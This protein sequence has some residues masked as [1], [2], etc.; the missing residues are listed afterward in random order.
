MHEYIKLKVKPLTSEM[1]AT[2]VFSQTRRHLCIEFAETIAAKTN[3]SLFVPARS[4]ICWHSCSQPSLSDV[5]FDTCSDI[6]CAGTPCVEF[7]KLECTL[8]IA[9]D[10]FV[11][12]L[13]DTQTASKTR[14]LE[15]APEP[16]EEPPQKVDDAAVKNAKRTRRVAKKLLGVTKSVCESMRENPSTALE[17]RRQASLLWAELDDATSGDA[18]YDCVT[19]HATKCDFWFAQGFGIAAEAG[20]KKEHVRRLREHMRSS[21]PERRRKLE[22]G[23]DKACCRVN[24]LTKERACKREYCVKAMKQRAHAR[25]GHVLRRMHE[26]GHVE[27]SVEQ[28]VA[29]DT[30]SPHLH[31]DPR[32]RAMDAHAKRVD[33]S[34][35]DVECLASSMV[36]H[37]ADKHGISTSRVDEELSKYGLSV[38]QLI[39]QPLKTAGTA[40][41]A[42]SSFKSNPAFADIAARVRETQRRSNEAGG[43]RKMSKRPARALHSARLALEALATDAALP[44]KPIKPVRHR[45]GT[46]KHSARA[47]L[48]NASYFVA[49]V[50]DAMKR[51][52]ANSEAPRA[53]SANPALLQ[54][55]LDVITAVVESDGSV[56]GTVVRSASA[57]GEVMARGTKLVNAVVQADQERVE[58]PPRRLSQSTIDSFYDDVELRIT[59]K[60]DARGRRLSAQSIGLTLPSEHTEQYGWVSGLVDWHTL[61][62]RTHAAARVLTKRNDALLAHVEATGQLP[63]G[64]VDAKH[65]TGIALLDL[66]VPPSKLGNKL[67]QLHAWTTQRHAS[68]EHTRRHLERVDAAHTAP[69]IERAGAHQS[70]A[71]ALIDASVVGDDPLQAARRVL[72][73]NNHHRTSHARKLADAFLGAAAAVPLVATTVSNKYTEYPETTGGYNAFNELIRYVIFDSLLCYLY[74]PDTGTAGGFG[75][76]TGVKTHRT[77]RLCFPQIPFAPT[78]MFTFR[79][80]YGLEGLNFDQIEYEAA[81]NSDAVRSVIDAL[82]VSWAENELSRAPYGALL[83]VAEGIDSIRNL[84]LMGNTT[85]VF[86]RGSMVVCGLAQLGGILFTALA[87]VAL[88]ALCVCAPLGSAIAVWIYRT[89]RQTEEARIK[90]NSKIDKLL[91]ARAGPGSENEALPLVQKGDR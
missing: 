57:L 37:I 49:G 34:V 21:E 7:L 81:C 78:K 50:A 24:K 5:N 9:D 45:P 74:R 27:L 61:V 35:S 68:S 62:Q 39:A 79:S 70:V 46:A 43:R 19:K 63:S 84:A 26:K 38:A 71:S 87:V 58:P 75:D 3:V 29:V 67:R 8:W 20:A 52:S 18:C 90:R 13:D 40:A 77:D 76:G 32:C 54:Q 82:G 53:H 47:W 59:A 16:L 41:S 89:L 25:M 86:Q 6:E 22:E 12:L 60:L 44:S 91:K 65:A 51:S 55:G 72:E 73:S 85:T 33:P 11:E 30:L 1:C 2:N 14:R 4:P 36:S 42:A 83:R 15:D 31:S 48:K 28:R 69:R 10:A 56:V 64:P 88:L 80:Y 66:N 23:L 17:L